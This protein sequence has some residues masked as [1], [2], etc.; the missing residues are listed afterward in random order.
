MFC[1]RCDRGYHTYCVGLQAIPDGSWQCSVCDPPAPSPPLSS[2]PTPVSKGK[3]GRP[4]ST[5][6]ASPRQ[7]TTNASSPKQDVTPVRTSSR[8][9]KRQTVTL[10]LSP[11]NNMNH[12]SN[13]S[14]A[15]VQT[16]SNSSNNNNTNSSSVNLVLTRHH[17][18]W[19]SSTSSANT[20]NTSHQQTITPNNAR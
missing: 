17:Q 3:R 4:S 16:N 11:S 7:P 5:T 13:S 15:D 10:P 6:R 1:D 18:Q 8:R 2:S 14:S 12:S 20:T 19:T 9:S